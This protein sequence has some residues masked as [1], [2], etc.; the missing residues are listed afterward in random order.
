M[1]FV[2]DIQSAFFIGSRSEAFLKS[3]LLLSV[4]Y[5]TRFKFNQPHIVNFQV[6][7]ALHGISIGTYRV[8]QHVK[9]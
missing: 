2:R 7:S 4:S 9:N 1:P 3:F 5:R 6:L 8:E